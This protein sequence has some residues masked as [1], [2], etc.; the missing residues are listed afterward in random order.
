MNERGSAAPRAIGLN[1]GASGD[2]QRSSAVAERRRA[3]Q[4]GKWEANRISGFADLFLD[5]NWFIFTGSQVKVLLVR[6]RS[7]AFPCKAAAPP[8]M[9]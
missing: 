4:R 7:R 9:D 8:P 5:V 1:Q 3:F 6:Q 2:P